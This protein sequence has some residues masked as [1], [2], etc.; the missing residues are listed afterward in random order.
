MTCKAGGESLPRFAAQFTAQIVPCTIP[1][2]PRPRGCAIG[3]RA[4][5]G[6]VIPNRDKCGLGSLRQ[7]ISAG[8]QSATLSA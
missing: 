1:L 4:G 8:D 6:E 5:A 7:K 2:P 3:A